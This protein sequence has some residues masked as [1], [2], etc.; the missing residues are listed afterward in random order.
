MLKGDRYIALRQYL[1]NSGLDKITLTFEKIAEIVGGLPKSAY[2]YSAPW[3]D[4]HG[5][6]LSQCWLRAGYTSSSVIRGKQ[7][8]FLKKD[9]GLENDSDN[10]IEKQNHIITPHNC[11]TKLDI[12]MAIQNIRKFHGTTTEGEHTRYRSWAHCYNAFRE[13]RN[14]EKNTDLLCLHLAWY[15][16]SWG[17]LRGGSFLL[18]MDYLVHKPLIKIVLSGKYD[19][20]FQDRHSSYMIPLTLDF[21]KEINGAYERKT[22]TDT[23]VTKIILGIFGCSP[24]YDRFFRYAA[25]KYTVCSGT[26]NE[27]SLKSLW[28]YYEEHS[29]AL[30][31]LRAELIIE[32]SHYTPMKLMDMCLFQ[33]GINELGQ[34]EDE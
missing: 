8:T 20:L 13:Y 2:D 23:F 11:S 10:T 19:L 16:A 33:I 4:R 32:G 26:F 34:E 3:Y 29:Q 12:G 25:K 27:S 6:P 21:A 18:R 28:C 22:L 30:E 7:V 5:G 14:D 17:M 9:S 24:A 31:A 15:M 1:E